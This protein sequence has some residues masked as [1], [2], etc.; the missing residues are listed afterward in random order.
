[1]ISFR[2]LRR[3]LTAER[4]LPASLRYGLPP[5]GSPAW[6]RL[7]E[8][9][10]L[11]PLLREIRDFARSARETPPPPLTF[12]RFQTFEAQGTRKEYEEPYFE[13]RGRL[14]ALVLDSL[15]EDTA[16]NK[17][18][19]EN[20]IW[21]ICNEYTWCL[22][23]CLPAGAANAAA[24]RVP[25][26]CQVDLFAA[27]T[28]HALAEALLLT[29]DML[30]PWIEYR[31][32]TEIERRVFRPLFNDPV[33][34]DWES[35]ADNWSA[36]CGGAVG[37]AA[38]LL[39]KD[40]QRLAG[41]IERVTRS[42]ECFLE[43]YGEDGGCAEG[44][45]YWF[46]GFGYYVYFSDMLKRYTE[47]GLDLL[48]GGKPRAIAAFP[49][50]VTLSGSHA[51]NY[52]DVGLVTLHTG[53]LSKLAYEL[54]TPVPEL[55]RV[56]PFCADASYRWPHVVRNLLWTDAELFG[57]PLPEGGKWLANLA[58]AVDR[59]RAGGIDFAFSA[60]GGH[61]DEPHNHNDLGQFILHVGGDNLLADPGAGE[62]S[63]DYFGPE[64][65]SLIHN[66]AEGHSVPAINGRLQQAG[67]AYAATVLH[68]N[69]DAGGSELEL[70]L[71]RAYAV[72]GL[73]SF[74]RSFRWHWHPGGDDGAQASLELTDSFEFAGRPESLVEQFVSLHAPELADGEIRWTG[75]S[76][77][78]A[79]E[80]DRSAFAAE[81]DAVATTD[82]AG[83]PQ[84]VYRLRLEALALS[85]RLRQTFRFRCFGPALS[86][87]E[88]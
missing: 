31:I 18:A 50:A 63:R 66:S 11:Q 53:L 72:P 5:R 47:G 59:R 43:G 83:R 58:V 45:G 37:M 55:D 22:P 36:V 29:G 54:G 6:T 32:R 15:L 2:T 64:R 3:E 19:L 24:G 88:E 17:Q 71:T 23:A 62:Y 38:L 61:N 21:D 10:H 40:G 8:Q 87:G 28:A 33:R 86:E 67:R 74:R 69:G 46:Y 34:F 82:F 13:R 73:E 80:Y 79:L 14:L 12:E 70:D 77:S 39:E 52:S 16:D 27:E 7:R 44:V 20:V 41:M 81:L 51:V 35:R 4:S 9:P 30:N 1:M 78:I 60:K 48:A 56:P 25:P 85:D 42:L 68:W 76:G 75:E 57:K 65:Y 84:T 49:A 26:E